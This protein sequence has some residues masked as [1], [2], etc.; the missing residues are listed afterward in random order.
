M[1]N[2]SNSVQSEAKQTVLIVD[3][4]EVN[5]AIL[6]DILSDKYEIIEAENGYEALVALKKLDNKISLVLL[7]VIMPKMDGFEV[8]AYMNKCKWIDDI[9]VIMISAEDASSVVE[10][11]YS[12][13]VTDF[14]R[15]PFD[16]N[17]VRRRAENTILL[18]AKQ[19]KL[20]GL[21]TDQIY[22]RQKSNSLMIEILS[23][24]VEFR[25]GE[26]GMHVMHI[27]MI[28]KILLNRL[29]QKTNKYNISQ[30]DIQ[31][32][33]IASALHDIGKIGIPDHILNK[34]GRLTS[35]EFEIMKTHSAVGAGMLDEMSFYKNEPLV[36]VAY[37]VCRWHH[38]R[39]DGR[40]YPDGLVGDEI[41][42][43]AQVV[44]IA[45]VYDALTS[46]RCYKKAFSHE[47]AL[48]MIMGGECGSFSTLMLECL[49]ECADEILREHRICS[50]GS[51]NKDEIS[52]IANEM[53]IHKKLGVSDRTLRLLEHERT[54]L[55]YYAQMTDDILFEYTSF[56][57]VLRFDEKSRKKL[58]LDDI[59]INPDVKEN[60]HKM[61]E[62]SDL[63]ADPVTN[64]KIT[65]IISMS[66]L[67]NIYS[68]FKELNWENPSGSYRCECK[69][70][71]K[72]KL[73]EIRFRIMPSALDD[74]DGYVVI[75]VISDLGKGK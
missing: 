64:E 32:I 20:A 55:H 42:I 23:H 47:K 50:I 21:V 75:G 60:N 74:G 63:I 66:D 73:M 30:E 71:G 35:E 65:T 6:S 33:S 24:I 49:E 37:E 69:L 61:L 4:S 28:T 59:V 44:A 31:L 2:H 70:G 3:D 5:R 9:P 36:K 52:S 45:D 17:V 18:Y 11:A 39:Y 10:H 15:C 27:S 72:I 68:L 41:P 16:V 25:N 67:H 46:D 58:K 54:K 14:I 51:K 8:L 40:G 48:E 56:P 34:P 1:E 29:V 19:K 22:E 57:S 53:M 26:S 43:S 7:D 13:G 38:E 62:T 12:L